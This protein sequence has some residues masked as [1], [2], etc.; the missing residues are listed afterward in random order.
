MN[1]AT[2]LVL[3]DHIFNYVAIADISFDQRDI[4]IVLGAQERYAAFQ[5][6][7]ERVVDDD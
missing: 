5:T 4:D 2:D 3:T 7:V 1:Y 6:L